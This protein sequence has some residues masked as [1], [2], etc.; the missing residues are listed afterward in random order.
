V[1][2]SI[3]Q[4]TGC[5]RRWTDWVATILISLATVIGL[6][7]L[8]RAIYCVQYHVHFTWFHC[9]GVEL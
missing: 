6:W 3:D 5:M 4:A 7:Q 8:C 1:K 9:Y 2:E